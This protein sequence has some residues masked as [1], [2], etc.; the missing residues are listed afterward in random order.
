LPIKDLGII[1]EGNTV[2]HTFIIKNSSEKT[3]YVDKVISSCGC[4]VASKK[5]FT[6]NPGQ[7]TDIKVEFNSFGAGGTEISKTVE[8]HAK[9]SNFPLI[10]TLKA[11]VKGIPP[12]KRIVITPVE[13]TLDGE[14]N[15]KYVLRLQV[16]SDPNIKFS[17]GVPEWLNYSM[18]KSKYNNFTGVVIWDIEIFLKSR[19]NERLN[20]D[21]VV[22]SN[23]PYF[24]RVT[25]SIKIEPTPRFVIN[26][27]MIVFDVNVQNQ[28]K[29]VSI[30]PIDGTLGSVRDVLKIQPS[31]DCIET[32][33]T[34]DSNGIHLVVLNKACSPESGKIEIKAGDELLGTIPVIFNRANYHVCDD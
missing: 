1:E 4:L 22:N 16:P 6:L 33:W 25:M 12:E 29:D 32:N 27:Y 14:P 8:I 30:K 7:S 18:Q 31:K 10:L 3:I 26:P 9:D 11:N 34:E 19:K 20:G 13:K 15:R 21:L 17:I 24:E 28:S 23:L 2:S 5:E